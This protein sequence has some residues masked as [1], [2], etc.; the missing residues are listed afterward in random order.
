M[1]DHAFIT[2]TEAVDSTPAANFLAGCSI[3]PSASLFVALRT[4]KVEATCL[5]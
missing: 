1:R 4:R 2:R 3:A 5:A